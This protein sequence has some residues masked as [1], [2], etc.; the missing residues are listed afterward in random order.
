[1]ERIGLHE[2]PE[3][4]G[5]VVNL[6][7]S[8]RLRVVVEEHGEPRAAFVSL[9]DLELLGSLERSD[10]APAPLG[11]EV[12]DI[13]KHLSE[14]VAELARGARAILRQKGSDAVALIGLR[15]LRVLEGVDARLDLEAAKRLLEGE[16]GRA[17]RAT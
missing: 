6:V 3:S 13:R 1:M 16:I 14:R 7:R 9:E 8:S 11:V 17:D 5:D 2:L 15:D 10:P 12:A 4:L